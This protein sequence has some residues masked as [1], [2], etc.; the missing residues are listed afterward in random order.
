M[1]AARRPLGRPG[2]GT[3]PPGFRRFFVSSGR[4]YGLAAVT[5][6]PCHERVCFGLPRPAL[7][8]GQRPRV[9]GELFHQIVPCVG[10]AFH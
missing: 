7:R 6:P 2:A 3:P 1:A 9:A 4:F 10:P 8:I 5:L